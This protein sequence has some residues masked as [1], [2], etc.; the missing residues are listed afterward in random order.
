MVHRRPRRGGKH[1]RP[2][3]SQQQSSGVEMSVLAKIYE[4]ALNRMPVA[5]D[6]FGERPYSPAVRSAPSNQASN[7]A[8]YSSSGRST[9]IDWIATGTLAHR[10]HAKPWNR[11]GC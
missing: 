6:D 1:D 10:I 4:V 7:S 8:S 9:T 2:E 3:L 5:A 11:G